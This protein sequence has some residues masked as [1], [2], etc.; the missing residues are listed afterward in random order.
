MTAHPNW[1]DVYK[2]SVHTYDRDDEL[3]V[4][5]R[6][7]LRLARSALRML[8]EEDYY[9]NNGTAEREIIDALASRN[10]RKAL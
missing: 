8:N 10:G 4:V 6:E 9:F 1:K 7:T 2:D 5:T 3:V